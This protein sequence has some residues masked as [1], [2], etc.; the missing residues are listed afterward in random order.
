MSRCDL[1]NQRTFVLGE[2]R[3]LMCH[4]VRGSSQ[5]CSGLVEWVW[6]VCPFGPPPLVL[7][8]FESGGTHLYPAACI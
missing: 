3:S 6:N 1:R 4:P 8:G 7:S 2:V 5:D